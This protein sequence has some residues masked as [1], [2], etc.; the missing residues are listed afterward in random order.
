ME[1]KVNHKELNVVAKETGNNAVL[2]DEEIDKLVGSVNELKEIW[3]GKDSDEFCDRVDSYL[4]DLR[5]VPEIYRTLDDFMENVDKN[6]KDINEEY[7]N[8]LRRV[9]D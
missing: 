5:I 2:L 6:Y 4:R 1:L 7:S 8:E 3:Q 9:V